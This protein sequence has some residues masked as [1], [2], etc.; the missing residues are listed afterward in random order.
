[1]G[2]MT[3]KRV[4]QAPASKVFETVAHIEQYTQAIPNITDVE[5]LSEN[6]TGVGARF[7]E[8]RKMGKREATTELEVTE[9]VKDERVRMVADAGG[10]IWDT[11][12]V[13]QDRGDRTTMTMT[14]ESRPHKW[15]AKIFNPLIGP[16]IKGAVGKDMDAVKSFCEG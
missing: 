10:A 8:T 7:R 1:M 3:I 12:F 13:I 5:F 2:T 16:M 9:Y 14:M 6:K 11:I 4:I 15:M